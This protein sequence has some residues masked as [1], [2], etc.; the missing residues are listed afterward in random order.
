V[1]PDAIPALLRDLARSL[2]QPVAAP[3]PRRKGGRP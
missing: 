3:S 2:L 1:Q